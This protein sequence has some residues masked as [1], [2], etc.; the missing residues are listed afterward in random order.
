MQNIEFRNLQHLLRRKV[1]ILV[2]GLLLCSPA[3]CQLREGLNLEQHDDKPY[4]FGI[5]LGYNKS[6]FSFTHHPVFLQRDTIMDVE[7]V[8]SAGINLAWLV[9][10][11]IADHLDLR[12]HP[13]DLTFSEKA[14]LYIRLP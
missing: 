4:H 8:N 13:L 7:S 3:I 11:R 1:S 14:F 12:L 2:L 10:L 5:N 9:N 6:H